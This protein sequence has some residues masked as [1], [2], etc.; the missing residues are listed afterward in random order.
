MTLINSEVCVFHNLA[1]KFL[2]ID[3]FGPSAILSP[4]P[5]LIPQLLGLIASVYISSTAF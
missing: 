1:T 4:L 3:K 2:E 5:I